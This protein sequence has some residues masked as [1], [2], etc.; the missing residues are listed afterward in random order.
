MTAYT[1][2]EICRAW[3]S[4]LRGEM[5]EGDPLRPPSSA[6]LLSR[7]RQ[8][9]K[10]SHVHASWGDYDIV[11]VKELRDAEKRQS[12]QLYSVMDLLHCIAGNREPEYPY[13]TVWKDDNGV[14]WF[15]SSDKQWMRFGLSERYSHDKPKRPLKRMDVA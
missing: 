5:A 12:S 8:Q 1:E 2:D 15:R 3:K 13:A 14:C 9:R 11:T 7:L 6:L 10:D 4:P